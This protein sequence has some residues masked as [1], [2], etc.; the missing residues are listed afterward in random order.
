MSAIAFVDNIIIV[1]SY[2]FLL[3]ENKNVILFFINIFYCILEAFIYNIIPKV[4][5]VLLH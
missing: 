1:P 5:T 3:L 2:W 4:K